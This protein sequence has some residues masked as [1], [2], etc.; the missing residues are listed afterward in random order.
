MN[1]M[2]SIDYICGAK[3]QNI[4][5]EAHASLLGTTK[6]INGR[7]MARNDKRKNWL[8]REMPQFMWLEKLTSP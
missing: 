3:R 7:H 4:V 6:S 5:T 1:T 2:Y 8:S